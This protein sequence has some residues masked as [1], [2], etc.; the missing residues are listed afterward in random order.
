MAVHEIGHTIVDKRHME[1][2]T[3]VNV[4][5]NRSLSLGKHCMDNTCAMYEVVDL[6]APHPEEGYMQLGPEKRFD[7]GLDDLI[8]RMDPDRY[9]CKS[10]LSSIQID[11]RFT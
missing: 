10:C 7:A 3:W 8:G 11:E 9:L 1:E 5:D 6:R 2:A 4:Q